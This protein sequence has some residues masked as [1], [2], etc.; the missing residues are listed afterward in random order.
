MLLKILEL[1]I[2]FKRQTRQNLPHF[3]FTGLSKGSSKKLSFE[4][5]LF[6]G[7]TVEFAVFFKLLKVDSV[8]LL[9]MDYLSFKICDSL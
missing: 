5:W 9:K 1:F 8:F 2:T 4:D 7:V 3:N 6:Y